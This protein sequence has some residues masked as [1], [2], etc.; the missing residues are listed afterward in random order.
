MPQT[1]TK[2]CTDPRLTSDEAT[3]PAPRQRVAVSRQ[4]AEGIRRILSNPQPPTKALRSA[5]AEYKDFAD[6]NPGW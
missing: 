1:L 3:T 4:E 5:F 2:T 6:Q